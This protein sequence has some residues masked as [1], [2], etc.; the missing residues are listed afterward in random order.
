MI[1]P[2]NRVLSFPEPSS[3][4]FVLRFWGEFRLFDRQHGAECS[5]HRRKARAVIAYLA[6]HSGAAVS[7]ERLSAL[8]WSERGDQQARASL[9]QTLFDLR[10]YA[11]EGGGLLVIDR[12]QVHLNALAWTSDIARIEASAHADDIDALC[13]ALADKEDRLCA[14]LDGLDPAFDEWLALE[15]RIQQDRLLALGA[16][17]AARGLRRRAYEGVSRLAT[18][19]QGVDE[20]NETIVQSG[21][22]ADHARGDCSAVRRRYRRLCEALRQELG[23][24][25]SQET[26]GLLREFTG[27]RPSSAIPVPTGP[28]AEPVAEAEAPAM[29]KTG[30][31]APP[32]PP[33]IRDAEA[34]R[35]GAGQD[36]AVH[37]TPRWARKRFTGVAAL[38]ALFAC[39]AG[40]AWLLQARDDLPQVPTVAVVPFRALEPDAASRDLSLQ[41]GDQL[42]G[43]LKDNVVGLSLVDP[44]AAGGAGSADLRVT[45]TVSRVAGEWRVRASLE[46]VR[47]HIALWAEE[48]ERPPQQAGMLDL[49]VATA[50]AEVVDDAVDALREKAARRDPRA[51][52]LVL[53]SGAAIKS[54]ALMNLG[55]PRR[56]LEEAVSRAP[57][58]VT[59]RATLALALLAESRLGAMSDRKLL[60]QRARRE[61]ETAISTD[62]AAAGAAY[63]TLYMMAR[64]RDPEDLAAAENLLIEGSAK[65]PHF[66]YLYMRR[67]RFLAEV[68]L[69]RDAVPY[70]QR[71]LALR[72][73]S[74]PLGYRYAE[75]LYALGSPELATRAI[76][77]AVSL[78]PEHEQ[79]RRVEFELAA[80]SGRPEHASALLHNASQGEPC[81][82][83]APFTPEGMQAMDLFLAARKSGAARDATKAVAALKAAVHH[84]QLH[85]RYLVFGAAALGRLDDAFAML[86][87]IA[88]L[89]GDMLAGDPGYLFEGPAA[90]LQRDRRFWRLAA[91]AGY[92]KYWRTRGAWPDFCSDPALPYDCRAE[93]ARVATLTPQRPQG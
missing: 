14:G 40:A 58:Y 20:T 47:G 93:A 88:G 4:R 10:P 24:G 75:A 68:G 21:M 28:A 25:P 91:K 56:L 64:E 31:E 69:A 52:A 7:R 33:R 41:L 74:S 11:M 13:D 29:A 42:T 73:L 48:F 87:E 70:C 34:G 6:T 37:T 26:E 82:C 16:A 80:F 18:E 71:A 90:P 22:K 61:A 19:L 63:D 55:E 17:V 30:L 2:N 46:D 12:D 66:A 39:G 67:C 72:P 49:E 27:A 60:A 44:S 85:P 5:P 79:T 51:L 50:A 23:V 9:R 83:A 53:Q 65:A 92:V 81:K 84:E 76:E 43:L 8:L 36:R 38:L 77:R 59:A 89:P 15:R 78:H 3:V 45:G 32:S 62:P 35:D 86:E 57:D 1:E 54:P